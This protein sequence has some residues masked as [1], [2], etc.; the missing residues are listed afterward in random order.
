VRGVSTPPARTAVSAGRDQALTIAVAHQKGGVGK[1]TTAAALGAALADLGDQVILVDADPQGSLSDSLG[2]PPESLTDTLADLLQSYLKVGRPAD[3][4]RCLRRL[5]DNLM[6]L[7]TND[8]RLA[9]CEIELA[10]HPRRALAFSDALAPLRSLGQWILIDCPPS[11]SPLTVSA[12]T[13]ANQLIVPISP[14]PMVIARLQMF[15]RTVWGVR[16][17]GL[18]PDLQIA[19]IVLTRSSP[20]TTLTRM[21]TGQL[22]AF[23]D[24]SVPILG[25]VRASVK[26]QEAAGHHVPVTWYEPAAAAA[27]EYRRIA[28]VLR[29]TRERI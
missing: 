27:Q 7:P 14:E 3:P 21:I 23:F 11:Q 29:G 4:R 20:G 22:R 2:Y 12:L 15:M 16:Q 1:T 26:V 19:G 9:L 6:L 18:N 25:E 8:D 10:S 17:E 28:E 5:S 13:F 24:G